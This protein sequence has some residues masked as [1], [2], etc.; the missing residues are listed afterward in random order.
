[1][2]L[3]NFATTAPGEWHELMHQF[4]ERGIDLKVSIPEIGREIIYDDDGNIE[5]RRY[6]HWRFDK[7]KIIDIQSGTQAEFEWDAD[8]DIAAIETKLLD[9]G[10]KKIKR[11]RAETQEA[12]DSHA[13]LESKI[14]GLL[15]ADTHAVTHAVT[16]Q[17]DLIL[18]GGAE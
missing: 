1:M 14:A 17:L 6:G 15:V 4:E 10:H 11:M 7:P 9:S 3:Y 18:H 13:K 8:F 2:K 5:E 12:I 16:N